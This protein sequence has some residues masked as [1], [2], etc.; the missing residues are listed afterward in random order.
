MDEILLTK[1]SIADYENEIVYLFVK[2]DDCLAFDLD[3]IR[4]NHKSLSLDS[5]EYY[6]NS[7]E[8]GLILSANTF[9]SS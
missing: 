3:G 9:F 4:S 7:I 8:D 1:P 2:N 5:I 6:S